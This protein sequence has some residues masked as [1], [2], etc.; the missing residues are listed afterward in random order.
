MFTAKIGE[1][2]MQIFGF[3]FEPQK[4]V[5]LLLFYIIFNSRPR[6]EQHF[7]LLKRSIF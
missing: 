6:S 3:E 5:F 1:M 7:S 2:K 4:F